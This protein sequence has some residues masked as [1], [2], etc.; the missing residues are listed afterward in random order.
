MIGLRKARFLFVYPL[1]AWLFLTARTSDA[2][3]R[4]GIV[5]ALLGEALRL[6]ANGY[7]GHRK[8]NDT[9]GQ[10]NAPKIGQLM[11]GGPYAYVRHP[12]YVGSFLIGLGLCVAVRAVWV[13]LGALACFAVLY[14]RKTREEEA[15]MR[16][17]VG[18]EYVAYEQAVGRWLP[19]RGRYAHRQG[20]WS[21]DGIR[22]SSEVKTLV[23]VVVA[24]LALSLRAAWVQEREV[25]TSHER[26]KHLVLGVCLIGLVA[27]EGVLEVLKRIR[28]ASRCGAS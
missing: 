11:T 10:P 27:T 6:W 16:E 17:E 22:A 5:L 15:M 18:A 8:V 1:A 7:V 26:V 23:W 9:R 14:G 19:W 28:Q 13:A 2:S 25:F 21:W 3:L 12:L 24:L 4:A 20:T